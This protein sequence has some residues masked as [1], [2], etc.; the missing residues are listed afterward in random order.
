MG[1]GILGIVPSVGMDCQRVAPHNFKSK[2]KSPAGTGAGS[3]GNAGR[4]WLHSGHGAWGRA[5]TRRWCLLNLAHLQEDSGEAESSTA[6]TA[7]ALKAF[8]SM[9][10]G[11][12]LRYEH[13]AMTEPTPL[14][15][16][17]AQAPT[18]APVPPT[19]ELTLVRTRSRCVRCE[20]RCHTKLL[21]DT[22]ARQNDSQNELPCSQHHF[23]T[24]PQ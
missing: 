17:L 22:A 16:R 20:H 19:E 21:C 23:R 6:A 8:W 10:G 13:Y 5:R 24:R 14:G 4:N 9:R 18:A 7:A 1:H 11:T 12:L 2:T 15:R 3:Y